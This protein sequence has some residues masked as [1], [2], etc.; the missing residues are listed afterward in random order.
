M[1]VAAVAAGAVVPSVTRATRGGTSAPVVVTITA[2][3]FAFEAPATVSA[4]EVTLRLRN[5]GLVAHQ[6]WLVR[7]G[8]LRTL[9]DLERELIAHGRLPEW[10]IDVGGP[11]A[12]A[13][14]A[15]GEV[16]V[17][18]VPGLHVILSA[19][20]LSDGTLALMKGMYRVL[21]V[22]LPIRPGAHLRTDGTVTLSDAGASFRGRLRSGASHLRVSNRSV[23]TQELRIYGQR[24]GA[25]P[26][27]GVIGIPPGGDAVLAI[28]LERGTYTMVY[29]P[30][31]VRGGSMH[32]RPA[33][34]I[35]IRIG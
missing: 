28:T 5:E 30:P 20:R 29:E 8:Q 32:P 23:H 19:A 15:H 26:V 34:P 12:I 2:T 11:S 18:V 3:D 17:R 4:G 1:I 35:Q 10:A 31:P 22:V 21:D 6:A 25:T 16:T 33:A 13:P 24:L 27:G 14:G 9:R 7:L